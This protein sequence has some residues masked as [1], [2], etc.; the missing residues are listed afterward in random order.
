MDVHTFGIR[1]EN[2]LG[3]R[4]VLRENNYRVWSTVLEQ[5]L[6]EKK[7]WGHVMGTAVPPPPA[8][9]I[10]PGVAAVAANG[11]APGIF[12]LRRVRWSCLL[13]HPMK[14][15]PGHECIRGKLSTFVRPQMKQLLAALMLSHI[16][17]LLHQTCD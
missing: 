7:L 4:I 3:R 13:R 10:A 16:Y 11:V 14:R 2:D 5:T 15:Q 17:P 8:R 9:V 6:C 1:A 12:A